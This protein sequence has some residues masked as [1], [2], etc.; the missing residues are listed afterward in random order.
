MCSGP[1]RPAPPGYALS[2]RIAADPH[3]RRPASLPTR[4][5]AAL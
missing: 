3:R 4:T 2:T 5:A 1:R